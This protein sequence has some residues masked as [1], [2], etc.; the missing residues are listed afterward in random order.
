M[1]YVSSRWY[2]AEHAD[3]VLVEIS[4]DLMCKGY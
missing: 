3:E 2:V 4:E 1:I